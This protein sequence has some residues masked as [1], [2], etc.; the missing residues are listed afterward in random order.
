M[1]TAKLTLQCSGE[2][3]C[4]KEVVMWNYYDHE[5]LVGTHYKYYSH[6]RI[7]AERDDWALVL[8]TKK[9]PFLPLYTSG[10]G[11]QYIDKNVMRTFHKDGLGFLLEQATVFEDLPDN[12]CKV[13]VTYTI[14]THPIF[15]LLEPVFHHL[16]RGWFQEVWGEDAPM[17]LRRWK[18][19]QL[20]FKNFSGLDYVNKKLPF[21]ADY[22]APPYDFTP[23][24]PTLRQIRS[25]EGQARPFD[26]S[27]ELGY[28]DFV[29]CILCGSGEHQ[30]LFRAVRDAEYDLYKLVDFVVCRNC[31]LISQRALPSTEDVR[32]FYPDD[33]RNHRTEKAGLLSSLKQIQF[34]RQA[35]R[36]GKHAAPASAILEIGCG[37]GGLLFAL[38]RNGYSNLYGSDMAASAKASCEAAGIPF[39]LGNAEQAFPFADKTFDLILLNN[40]IEHLVNPVVFLRAA[41]ERLSPN[42]KIIL[43]TPN[44]RAFDATIFKKHWA[45]LHAPRHTFIFNDENALRLKEAAGFADAQVEHLMDPGQWAISVQNWMQDSKF[46]RSTL[47]SG[48]AWY[49]VLLSILATPLALIGQVVGRSTSIFVVLQK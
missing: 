23:P 18:M 7:L 27:V 34:Q 26:S 29:R 3:D 38:K 6:A 25:T 20:G 5:H 43:I 42:G 19:H 47:R 22:K 49:T 44:S 2:M 21:P 36:L 30:I 37:S 39:A 32:E 41:K 1:K 28:D 35:T 12:R 16:F 48:M 4:P 9:M 13:T 24:V 11:L 33:Y 45:G 17:R 31:G 8:R 15:K 14:N 46:T 40:V 10:I